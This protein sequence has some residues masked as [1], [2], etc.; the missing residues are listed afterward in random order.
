MNACLLRK[1]KGTGPPIELRREAG[2]SPAS[3]SDL[4]KNSLQQYTPTWNKSNG[5]TGL[6]S[7]RLVLSASSWAWLAV[8]ALHG[9][10]YDPG[11]PARPHRRI[12]LKLVQTA[13]MLRPFCPVCSLSR[14]ASPVTEKQKRYCAL[15]EHPNPWE[16]NQTPGGQLDR[17]T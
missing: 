12:D 10:Q 7:V 16:P 15:L 2:C 1:E 9:G 14:N 13:A 8:A 5:R 11:R 6:V 17:S 3:L 4:S